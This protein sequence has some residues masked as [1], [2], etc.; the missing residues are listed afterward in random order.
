MQCHSVTAQKIRFTA[1]WAVLIFLMFIIWKQDCKGS[2][3]MVFHM[4]MKFIQEYSMCTL[5]F[6]NFLYSSL[7]TLNNYKIIFISIENT[8]TFPLKNYNESKLQIKLDEKYKW[9]EQV[10][11]YNKTLIAWDIGSQFRIVWTP[12]SRGVCTSLREKALPASKHVTTLEGS[13]FDWCLYF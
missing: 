1:F 2:R 6:K 4:N 3:K 10:V 13:L 12:Y 5:I 8:T 9:Y 7:N 11:K